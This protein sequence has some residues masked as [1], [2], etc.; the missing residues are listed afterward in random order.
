METAAL[1]AGI[2]AAVAVGWLAGSRTAAQ[3]RKAELQ[4]ATAQVAALESRISDLQ[5][6]VAAAQGAAAERLASAAS[7]R[8]MDFGEGP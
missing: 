2:L 3:S 4:A 5:G 6:Q 8:L 1:I 7:A